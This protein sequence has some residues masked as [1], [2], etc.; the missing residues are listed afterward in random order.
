[1]C[2]L[3][4]LNGWIEDRMRASITG[5]FRV[6]GENDNGRRVVEFCAERGLCV[7]NTY[8]KHRNLLKY[9]RG[10]GGVGGKGY[11]RSGAGEE[12]YA[13]LCARCE[14]S[15]RNDTRSLRSD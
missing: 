7:G 11:D 9:T 5:A 3:G 6:P 13:A 4:D 12:G 8:F 2:I 15:E 10:Q 1:M 14:G